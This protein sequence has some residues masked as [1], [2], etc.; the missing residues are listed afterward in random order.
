MILYTST[1]YRTI[2]YTENCVLEWET[3]V[4]GWWIY[5]NVRFINLLHYEGF[6]PQVVNG[7]A[8]SR[9][10]I[11]YLKHYNS[12]HWMLLHWSKIYM[13]YVFT[14]YFTVKVFVFESQSIDYLKSK[15]YLL[16][17]H[18]SKFFSTNYSKSGFLKQPF[19]KNVE[20]WTKCT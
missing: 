5:L 9:V 19:E 11:I 13:F 12:L 18:G 7:L 3:S 15:Y 17:D 1:L 14:E 6:N 16:K 4:S 2:P 8:Y 20:I 10:L